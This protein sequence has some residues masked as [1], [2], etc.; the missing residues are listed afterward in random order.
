M[1][2]LEYYKEALLLYDH[3]EIYKWLKN[4]RIINKAGLAHELKHRDRYEP[5]FVLVESF[6][7]DSS[8][9]KVSIGEYMDEPEIFCRHGTSGVQLE[10]EE[11]TYSLIH[12][13]LFL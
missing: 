9:E 2:S 12:I 3:R 1:I 4:L 7:N 10:C 13:A 6:H 8:C 11:T 5:S